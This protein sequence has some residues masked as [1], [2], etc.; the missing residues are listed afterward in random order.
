MIVMCVVVLLAIVMPGPAYAEL[1]ITE[2]WA[3]ADAGKWGKNPVHNYD[4]EIPVVMDDPNE[5]SGFKWGGWCGLDTAKGK[6]FNINIDAE[7]KDRDGYVWWM[8]NPEP[9]GCFYTIFSSTGSNVADR[10]VENLETV[11]FIGKKGDWVGKLLVR[12]ANGDWYLSSPFD[13][14][15]GMT[16]NSIVASALTWY[17]IIGDTAADMNE[18]DAGGPFEE[19]TTNGSGDGSGPGPLTLAVTDMAS[20]SPDLSKITGSGL[21]WVGGTG[22]FEFGPITWQGFQAPPTA[23]GAFPSAVAVNPWVKLSWKTGEGVVGETVYFGEDPNNLTDVTAQAVGNL[24]DPGPLEMGKTYYWRVDSQQP[25]GDM[26]PPEDG[27]WSFSVA[28]FATV[29][30]MDIYTPWDIPD[31]N[32]FDVWLDGIGNCVDPGNGT[33]STISIP[34][35]TIDPAEVAGSMRYE[36]DNDGS[37]KT[38]CDWPN[39]EPKEKYSMANANVA[40]LPSGIGSDWSG[41]GG[42]ALWLQ[43]YGMANNDANEPMWI[44]LGDQSGSS[45]TVI[46][47][48]SIY[49]DEDAGDLREES[50]HDWIIDLTAFGVDLTRIKDISVGFG[51]AGAT[52]PGGSGVVYFRSLRFYVSQCIPDRYNLVA[53]LNGDCIVDQADLDIMMEEWGLQAGDLI[54]LTSGTLI[55]GRL[56]E[57]SRVEFTEDWSGHDDEQDRYKDF[58]AIAQEDGQPV[59]ELLFPEGGFWKFPRVH[60]SAN[61]DFTGTTT[62]TIEWKAK[63]NNALC[64]HGVAN[65]A[66]DPYYISKFV[67]YNNWTGQNLGWVPNRNG[68]YAPPENAGGRSPS[69]FPG[70]LNY[71]ALVTGMASDQY[72]TLELTVV[73]DEQSCTIDYTVKQGGTVV[74]SG[75]LSPDPI[76]FDKGIDAGRTKTTWHIGGAYGKANQEPVQYVTGGF[77]KSCNIANQRSLIADLNEDGVVDQLDR[78]ILDQQWDQ[79]GLW[80]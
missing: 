66:H 27:T 26:L 35:S 16:E 42:K 44:K 19:L 61:L 37:V 63:D 41:V 62:A 1:T 75:T 17:K 38:P 4:G 25:N 31:N 78:D 32:M 56:D 34:V 58:Y 9:G 57:Q 10:Y 13:A 20:N 69:Y 11:T 76:D 40:D 24:Y 12:D 55:T 14:V 77:V 47:G 71:K 68:E 65:N 43:F 64:L 72:C 18:L 33:G 22:K 54:P 79:Q 51:Q 28:E 59:L 29:D 50:W 39:E 45:G 21:V 3:V 8:G 30:D 49:G 70:L 53:D 7:G 74:G 73:A 36:Y 60:T 80:P 5:G 15:G 52:E 2:N 46:Y 23:Y 6:I 67:L 48:E